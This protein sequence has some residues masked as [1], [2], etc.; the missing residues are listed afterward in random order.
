MYVRT[1]ITG[2]GTLHVA[3]H[4]ADAANYLLPISL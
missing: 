1:Y 4:V 3:V 2:S